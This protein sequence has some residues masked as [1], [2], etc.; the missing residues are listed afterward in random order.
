MKTYNHEDYRYL[1]VRSELIIK[2]GIERVAHISMPD[3]YEFHENL[4]FQIGEAEG[5]RLS[6]LLVHAD[7]IRQEIYLMKL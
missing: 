1:F 5:D 3:G 6:A 7:T 2:R 4:L